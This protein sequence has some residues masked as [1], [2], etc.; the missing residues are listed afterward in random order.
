MA[1]AISSGAY[2]WGRVLEKAS[3]QVLPEQP[4]S[5]VDFHK[6]FEFD[7]GVLTETALDRRGIGVHL[8][9]CFLRLGT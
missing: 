1:V 2:I 6:N 8:L 7:K 5:A 9:C 3:L 4:G